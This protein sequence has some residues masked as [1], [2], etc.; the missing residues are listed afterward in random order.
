MTGTV[1]QG[2]SAFVTGSTQ[3][4]GLEIAAALS[5]AGAGVVL[6]GLR[7]DAAALL[8][9]E[10]CGTVDRPAPLI[11]C[12][13]ADPMPDGPLQAAEAAV[14]QN[15]QIDLLV[16]N[17]GTFMD[18]PFLDMPLEIFDRTM[19]LNV[20]SQFVLIQY[21]ARRW[22]AAG[23]RGRILVTGSINGRLS[24]PTH[25]A[26]DASKGAIDAMVRSLCVSLA[27][28]GIRING[29]APGLFRTPLTEPAIQDPRFR[30]WM[31][32]HTPNGVVPGPE[33]CGG[34]AVFLLSDAAEHIHGQMLLVD[35]GMSVWQQPDPPA[36]WMPA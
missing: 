14:H 11:C 24:E 35:G 16:C 10:R 22:V 28:L 13:L 5:A 25:V 17:A 20:Y 31:E 8:A 12:D 29:M 1:L 26:Y 23:V 15:P 19:K 33:V 32:V 18:Q 21:F 7:S 6:H 2:R 3:G 36:E 27:P 9:A 34:T 4:V 30:R